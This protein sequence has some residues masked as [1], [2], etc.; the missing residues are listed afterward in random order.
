MKNNFTLCLI[1]ILGLSLLVSCSENEIQEPICGEFVYSDRYV[2]QFYTMHDTPI[3]ALDTYDL[4][5]ST[6]EFIWEGSFG[7]YY[8]QDHNA[9]EYIRLSDKYGNITGL[10]AYFETPTQASINDFTGV[11]ITSSSDFPGHPAGTSL[12]DI[13]YIRVYSAKTFLDSKYSESLID[14]S[15]IV[16][17]NC[18]VI[19]SVCRKIEKLV[20]D[21]TKE[22]LMLIDRFF[23]FTFF[24]M[25]IED[26]EVVYFTVSLEQSNEEPIV[27][28]YGVNFSKLDK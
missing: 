20:K 28:T 16:I 3:F 25:P 10:N 13:A 21:I 5:K 9:E 18:R 17:D 4:E 2:M 27:S 6:Y 1:S 26:K 15:D 11:N 19:S 14:F 22:D 12:N 7:E 8:S 23:Y 24:D